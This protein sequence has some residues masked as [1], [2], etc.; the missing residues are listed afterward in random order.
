MHAEEERFFAGH[1]RAPGGES[2]YVAARRLTTELAFD[3]V[4]RLLRESAT[5]R[6][7]NTL[8]G[9]GTVRLFLARMLWK[10]IEPAAMRVL[11]ARALSGTEGCA[12]VLRR[13]LTFDREV[14]RSVSKDTALHFYGP[15]TAIVRRWRLMFAALAASV[16]RELRWML[17]PAKKAREPIGGARP[18]VLLLQEDD[19]SMDRS[20]RSQPHWLFPEASPPPFDVYVMPQGRSSRLPAD[21]ASLRTA[22]VQVIGEADLIATRRPRRTTPLDRML[23]SA[24][25]K[26]AV[27]AVTARQV[28]VAVA[29]TAVWGLF[30]KA[31]SMA[32]WCQHF[33]IRAYLTGENYPVHSD[34]MQV[35]AQHAGVTTLSYQYSNLAFATPLMMTTADRLIL[36][37]RTFAPLWRGPGVAAGDIE[38]AGY[39]FDSAFPVLRP[40][41]GELRRTLEDAGAGFVLCYFDESVQTDKFG[42]IGEQDHRD[43]LRALMAAVLEDP[44]LALVV[45]SQFERN[46]P[47]RR[48]A[49][50]PMFERARATGRY[51][52]L[53]HGVHRN[54]VFPAEAALA[55]D[56]CIGHIVGATAA[57][58]AA[59]A[60]RRCA[61]LNPYGMRTFNDDLYAR[62]DIVC[63]SI[64]ELLRSVR[65]LR[66][67]DP[68]AAPFGDWSA[69]LPHMDPWRD[70]RSS[71]R[72]RGILERVACGTAVRSGAA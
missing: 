3:A 61:L 58:E 49:A 35:V 33:N 53:R 25:Q 56:F 63:S 41:A 10:D 20:H 72:L 64:D 31:R 66:D 68:A 57:L 42:L 62:V 34:A 30:T 13:P 5:L 24:A 43:E 22:G 55:A 28:R 1:L 29:L 47:S 50:D 52:E 36:F 21:E 12:L 16:G 51:V 69:I 26:I 67:G 65:R 70:G 4:D 18:G 37:S 2:V 7:A 9:R 17:W 48:Y 14:L 6:D 19:L 23:A 71:V 27:R 15:T 8:G 11:I 45:K 60:G 38:E 44:S 40:R 39:V 54:T 59:L 32:S 46:S